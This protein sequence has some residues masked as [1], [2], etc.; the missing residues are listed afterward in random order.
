VY[1]KVTTA[2]GLTICIDPA[3]DGQIEIVKLD[4]GDLGS[5]SGPVG[6]DNPLPAVVR[7]ADAVVA[8]SWTE[9]WA[10]SIGANVEKTEDID[11]SGYIISPN[12][13]LILGVMNPS[14]YTALNAEMQIWWD[15]SGTDRYMKLASYTFA[16]SNGEGEAPTF[17]NS[18]PPK[19]RVSLKNA[20]GLGAGQGFTAKCRLWTF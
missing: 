17:D 20:T 19:V 8:H 16:Q 1:T 12:G 15:D 7:R 10:A 5:V 13:G 4:I 6:A 18:F 9:T 3:D 11:L 14:P 2:S